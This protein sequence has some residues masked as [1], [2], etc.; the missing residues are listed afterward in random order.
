MPPDWSLAKLNVKAMLICGIIE[1]AVFGVWWV[2]NSPAYPGWIAAEFGCT[3]LF[4]MAVLACARV[5][6][7]WRRALLLVAPLPAMIVCEV[8]RFSSA[9]AS[10]GWAVPVISFFGGFCLMVT[11]FTARRQRS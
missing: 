9:D 6:G 11:A 5:K 8:L 7:F 2:V 1:A 4:G 3:F 10:K